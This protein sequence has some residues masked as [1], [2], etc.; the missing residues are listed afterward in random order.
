MANALNSVIAVVNT[1]PP[2]LPLPRTVA[3][4]LQYHPAQNLGFST[5]YI[6]PLWHFQTQLLRTR[7]IRPWELFRAWL[8]CS[9]YD[10]DFELMLSVIAF[11]L[12]AT[13]CY[14]QLDITL[15][16]LFNRNL[17]KA[18]GCQCAQMPSFVNS[19]TPQHCHPCTT[20]PRLG[21]K[22]STALWTKKEFLFFFRGYT[23]GN[24]C[25]YGKGEGC[26]Q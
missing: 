1:V 24:M 6:A 19:S 25:Y 17:P 20:L 2:L 8:C 10:Y 15:E 9:F 26:L 18:P 7:S 21:T 3:R 4:E 13:S 14:S 23:D 11:C 22:L 5:F 16:M 12:S